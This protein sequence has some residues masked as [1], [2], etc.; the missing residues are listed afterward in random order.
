[1]E[2]LKVGAAFSDDKMSSRKKI[3]ADGKKNEGNRFVEI[4]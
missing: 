2:E 4:S 1:M 3:V